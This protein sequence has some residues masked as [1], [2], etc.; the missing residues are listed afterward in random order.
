MRGRVVVLLFG[1]CLIAGSAVYL[2]VHDRPDRT[3]DHAAD[4]ASDADFLM[5]DLARA[6]GPARQAT[7]LPGIITPSPEC[8]DKGRRVVRQELIYSRGT[9]ADLSGR[10]VY[11]LS[12]RG[13]RAKITATVHSGEGSYG[14]ATKGSSLSFGFVASINVDHSVHYLIYG[15]L[16]CTKLG[17]ASLYQ[18]SG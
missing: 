2:F 9:D 4:L 12:H 18:P 3:A 1:L 10:T 13:Y 6:F 14:V 16:N 11:V 7:S 5:R 8:D 15:Y 17:P